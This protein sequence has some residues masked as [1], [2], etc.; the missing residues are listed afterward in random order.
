MY[1]ER[2][3]NNSLTKHINTLI[4]A[5]LVIVVAV[6]L[7]IAYHDKHSSST[8]K[9]VAL[10][11]VAGENFW[12]NITSQIGGSHVKV[13]SIISN[14]NTDPHLYE[15]DAHDA[16]AISS[17]NI[18]IE[19]GLGYDDF[20]DKIMAASPNSQRQV[21]SAAK[22]LNI[23]GD[24]PNPHLWY[25][26]P[27]VLEVAGAIEQALASKDPKDASTYAA[28]LA[29]FKSSLQPILDVI[30]QIK[31]KYPN[32]PVAYTERVPGYLL[33]DAGLDVKTPVE[34]ASA[35]EDGDDP[36]PAD[37]N[38]MDSLM[39]N[40]GIRVLLYNAQATSAATVH[41]RDLATQ[42]GIP[43]IGVTETLPPSE[44][45]YQTWQL[46]QAKALLKALG[47]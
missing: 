19:N 21:L 46:D 30:N 14:P 6:G 17:A 35:T 15:S 38:T 45:N 40:H 32:A 27:R 20:M 7:I 42:A 2:M 37:T 31:T 28:N 9:N 1:I 8:N 24:D 41:V 12:G 44:H 4:V 43:V 39:T 23:T 26:I 13:T 16:G 11:V 3:K 18:V 33:A 47:G 5:G 34:F 36:T 25:D 29:T 22:I 10:Q